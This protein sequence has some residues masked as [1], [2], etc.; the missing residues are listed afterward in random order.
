MMGNTKKVKLKQEPF[1]HVLSGVM[2]VSRNWKDSKFIRS[3]SKLGCI[4]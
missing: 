4:S 2:T 3:K 1:L